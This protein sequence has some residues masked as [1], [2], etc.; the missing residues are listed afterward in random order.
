M[1]DCSQH[2]KEV[3]GISDMKILAKM[4]RD[5]HHETRAILIDELSTE[6]SMEGLED[7]KLKPQLADELFIVSG[8]LAKAAIHSSFVWQISKPFMEDENRKKD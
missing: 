8:Y 6:I 4:I 2:K 3:G 7:E 1:S 5:L